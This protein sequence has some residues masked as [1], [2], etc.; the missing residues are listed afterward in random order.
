MLT[1][2]QRALLFV[3]MLLVLRSVYAADAQPD[4]TPRL[5]IEPGMHFAQIWRIDVDVAERFVVSAA[6]DKTARVWDLRTGKLLKVLRPPLGDG[7]EGKLYAV[8]ISPDGELIAVAGLTSENGLNTNIYLFQRSSG[9][10]QARIRD[11]PSVTAHLAFSPNG[12]KLAVALGLGEG[13]RLFSSQ[14]WQEIA[15]DS[16]YGDTSYSV[17]FDMHGRV[18]STS[19]DG[20]VRLY[21]AELKLLH[22]YKTQGG[23]SPFLARFSPDGKQVAVGFDDSTVVE[24]LASDG[25]QLVRRQDTHG[26][27]NGDMSKIAWSKDGHRLYAGGLYYHDDDGR[28][29]VV[30]DEGSGKRSLW[31]ASQNAVMDIKPLNDGGV[32]VGTFDPTLIRLD[33]NG[34]VMWKQ[35]SG[36]LAFSI[37]GGGRHFGLGKSATDVVFEFYRETQPGKV[38]RGQAFW[39]LSNLQLGKPSTNS[40]LQMPR[41]EAVGMEITNWENNE[42]PKLNGQ[43]LSLQ[44]DEYSRSLAIDIQGKT[45]ALGTEWA[46]RLYNRAGDLKWQQSVPVAWAV[47]ISPDDR[48]VVAALGDGTIRWYEKST[49]KERL[50]F[51]LHPDEKR[52]VT[53]TP[54][55]FYAS[56]EGAED[57][58]GYHLNRG[59]DKEA[60]FFGVEQFRDVFARADLVTKALDD[61]Y[62][63]LAQAALDKVGDINS[64]LQTGLPPTLD[65]A[66]GL[67]HTLK[68]RNFDLEL[69]LHDQG[70]GIGRVEYRVNG[71]VLS[72]AAARPLAPRSPAGQ[73]TYRRP[74]SLNNGDNT[75]EVTAYSA[76]DK[77]ASKPV[78]LKVQVNDPVQREPSLYVLSIGVTAYRDQSFALKYAA[79]D[80]KDFAATLQTQG[81]GMFQK[82]E[83]K[84]LQDKDASLANI[85][86]AFEEMAGKVQPQDVFVLYLSGHGLIVDG[87]YHYVP[88]DVMYENDEAIRTH[89]LSEEKL[90]DW[91][92]GVEA[93]KRMMVIDTCHAGKAVNTL[94]SLDTPLA[95]GMDDKAAISR[96]MKATGT[97]VLAAAS[98]QQQALEGVVE[99]EQGNGLFT[100]VLLKG[101]QGKADIIN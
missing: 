44:D 14:N 1:I 2:L 36:L 100:H 17:D 34:Q 69:T 31:R 23:S 72:N 52:W 55:G 4:S 40:V 50:A 95:R 45:F 26:I 11:L 76:N 75:I 3:F 80:A 96:L 8:A 46:V 61:N 33:A 48:W 84:L 93:G 5:R 79:D 94:A 90:R 22:Q 37:R 97:S 30:W 21:D 91:L 98:T 71:E 58:V 99:G 15:R 13:I 66:G 28:P 87:R 10:L 70:S 7:D 53:W 16:N 12:S 43:P 6:E 27:D 68:Q 101:L 63:Q 81:S 56:A 78:T 19:S 85:Q 86:A 49:G 42:Q 51:Y 74:F 83:Q 20:L 47:N 59:A 67:N 29:L 18:I 24:I 9:E 38:K 25:L 39:Q 89:A 64:M 88:Q 62:S 57:L 60:E 41:H 32:I 35:N 54:Q 77:V 73:Q 65:V 82:V 92:S